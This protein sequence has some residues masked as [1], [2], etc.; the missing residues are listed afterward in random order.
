[1][2]RDFTVR[3]HREGTVDTTPD[4]ELVISN[5]GCNGFNKRALGTVTIVVEKVD[6]AI[7]KQKIKWG[8]DNEPVFNET[9]T[10]DADALLA[11]A[12]KQVDGGGENGEIRIRIAT[13]L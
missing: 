11:G 4:M 1:M 3:S 13:K 2:E 12:V 9:Q 7:T 10:K 8:V 5:M 6:G